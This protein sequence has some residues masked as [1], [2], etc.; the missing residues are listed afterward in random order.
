MKTTIE[1]NKLF[2]FEPPN[3]LLIIHTLLLLVFMITLSQKWFLTN[4][5]Y[6]CFYVPFFVVSGPVVY[7]LAHT[8]QH[9][10]E[11]FF[12]SDQKTI[13]WTIV[14]GTVCLVF[15]GLQWWII[16][17]LFVNRRKTKSL[18]CG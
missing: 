8:M 2:C 12:T 13:I 10:S 15:G 11:M 1:V 7:L 9:L 5:P 14:P 3:R 4:V 18:S 6:E 17:S 16:E